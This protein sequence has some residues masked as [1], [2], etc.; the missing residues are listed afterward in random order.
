MHWY[1]SMVIWCKFGLSSGEWT[2]KEDIHPQMSLRQH[3]VESLF[4]SSFPVNPAQLS[5]Q[6][7]M[8]LAF[9][10]GIKYLG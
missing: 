1:W 3:N 2:Q 9:G 6:I 5:H 10:V 4:P 7:S 8:Q